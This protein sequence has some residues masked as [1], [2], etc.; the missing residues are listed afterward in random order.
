[1]EHASPTPFE[2]EAV[3][4]RYGIAHAGPRA[5]LDPGVVESSP[6]AEVTPAHGRGGRPPNSPCHTA[7]VPVVCQRRIPRA[8]G[9]AT[10]DDPDHIE[11]LRLAVDG[12]DGAIGPDD[13]P[14]W[15][16]AAALGDSPGEI[17]GLTQLLLVD[18]TGAAVLP[19]GFAEVVVG[20]APDAPG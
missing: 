14:V 18:D 19:G 16:D 8:L 12:G 10:I 20:M 7:A 13:R 17:G 11:R 2:E 4:R 15:P 5:H 9:Y 1:M 3:S 6:L